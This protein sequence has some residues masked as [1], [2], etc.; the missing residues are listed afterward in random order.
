MGEWLDEKQLTDKGM[1]GDGI[2]VPASY[3]LLFDSKYQRQ[4]QQKI[5]N[6]PQVFYQFTHVNQTRNSTGSINP[7]SAQLKKSG[8]SGN[9]TFVAIPR[10]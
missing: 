3:Y 5:D 6:P 10:G 9:V 1:W 7:L 2:R 8:I 4:F